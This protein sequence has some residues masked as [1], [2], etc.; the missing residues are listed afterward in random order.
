MRALLLSV[1]PA[2]QLATADPC[3]P[4]RL[5]DSHGQFGVS[6]LWGLCSFLLGPRVHKLL[7]V[8]SKSLFP[9]LYK[10]WWLYGGVNGHLLQE[11]LCHTQI[12]CTQSSCSCSSP[13]LTR[14]FSG[15]T[16][17]QFWLSLCGVSGSWCAQGMFEPSEHLQDGQVMVESS[18]KMLS[19]GEG[20]GKPLQYS[21]LEN[22]M[23]SMKRQTD[24]TLNDELPR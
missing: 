24:K 13:L 17:T 5:L 19:T 1:P 8:P 23:N 16:Q 11:G 10:F 3:L 14:T 22:P 2:L 9:V 20:N 18:D 12:Y 15:D 21:C 4:R 7:F 6:L